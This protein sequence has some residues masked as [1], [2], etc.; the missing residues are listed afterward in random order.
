MAAPADKQTK[1]ALRRSCRAYRRRLSPSEYAARSTAIVARAQAL[2]EIEQAETVHVYWPLVARHEVD[3]RPLI[4]WLHAKKK[5]I[6]LPAVI[7]FSKTPQ[8]RPRL[9]HRRYTGDAVLRVNRWGIHEPASGETVPL[10]EIDVVVVPALGAGRNGHRIGHGYGFYDELLGQL[11]A[12]SVC[13]V[14]EHCLVDHVPAGPRDVACSILV[15]E[16]AVLR[17]SA[18]SYKAAIPSNP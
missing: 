8:R 2:P 9:A 10:D 16:H 4:S 17:P 6:V 7:T 14:Y 3:T 5:Q 18:S 1:E 13:L 11:T 15:T 12:P